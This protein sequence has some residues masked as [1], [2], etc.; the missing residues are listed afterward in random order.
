MVS[1]RNGDGMV[2]V[3]VID[4]GEVPPCLAAPHGL[5]KG[6]ALVSQLAD[7]FG[8]DGTDRWLLDRERAQAVAR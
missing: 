8:A 3:D 4:Q 2:R 7:A 6:L 5:G 1:V